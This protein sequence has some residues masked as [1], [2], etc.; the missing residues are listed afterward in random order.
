MDRIPTSDLQDPRVEEEEEE[1]AVF[2]RESIT[3]RIRPT[4]NRRN[5]DL[6]HSLMCA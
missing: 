6:N 1:E 3:M 5:T 4:L 2:T